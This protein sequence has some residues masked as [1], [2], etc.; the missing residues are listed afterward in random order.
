MK[1]ITECR[2]SRNEQELIENQPMAFRFVRNDQKGLEYFPSSIIEKTDGEG[3]THNDMRI[4]HEAINRPDIKIPEDSNIFKMKEDKP[5]ML[6][7]ITMYNENFGQLMQSMAGVVRSV[8]ELVN[9]KKS[10][11]NSD[12]FGIVLICD[13]IDKVDQEFMDKLERHSLFDPDLCYNTVLTTDIND[14]HVKRTFE[15]K[16]TILDEETKGR[17]AKRYSYATPNVGHI[18]SKKL[19]AQTMVQMFDSIDDD[20]KYECNLHDGKGSPSDWIT[21]KKKYELP[22]INF[23]FCAKHENRGKIESHLWFFK[24]FCAYIKPDYCQMIDIGTIPLKNSISNIC[25][26]MDRYEQVGGACGEIEVFAPTDKEL[27]YPMKI[28]EDDEGNPIYKNRNC[29]QRFEAKCLVLAQ[30]VEYKISHYIDKAFETSFGF[31]SVLPGAFS[32]FRWEAIRGDPLKSFFK[33]LESDKHTAKEA[34]MY[35]AEDRVMCLEI[36]RRYSQNW[37]LRY[38]PGC[39]ALTDPPTSIVGLIKQRRRWTNGSLFA[40]WYVIDHLNL[41]TRSG[42]SCC[43]QVSLFILYIYMTLNF[44][45]SLMLVGSLFATFSIFIRSFFEDE[46]CDTF[47]GARAFETAYLGILFIFTLMSI[48]K[49]IEK[50]AA[51]YTVMVIL[52]GIFIFVSI[53]FGFKYFWEET[54]GE[55]VGYLMIVTLAS[56]YFVPPLLNLTRINFCKYIVGMGIMIFLSPMYINIFII[57]SMANLHDISWG[58]R[59]T[60]SKKS[61]ETRKNLEKFR[62]LCLIVWI[63]VNAV[64]GYGIIYISRASQRFYILVLTILVS[65]TVLMKIG[66]A[67]IHFYYD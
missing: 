44:V 19:D 64:Y 63:F 25:R 14:D 27:G 40:S 4:F 31:V 42:H 11:Y 7:C 6:F 26:Y 59:D 52:F 50:S 13:G 12:Q 22:D 24:G 51:A 45:F 47:G 58:N 21:S 15:K 8:V 67:I 2:E 23:F 33:G 65:G 43:R 46:Q 55:I 60:D 10:V 61:I 30:Y 37:V 62:A 56:S 38:I 18:F 29:W 53:G 41:I 34:N 35:L 39:K 66:F 36:L 28:G 49:P 48:T 17:S 20:E 5:K 3:N 57:Y 1:R 54:K 32:T 16:D 9:L